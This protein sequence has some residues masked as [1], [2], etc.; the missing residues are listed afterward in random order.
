MRPQKLPIA[1]ENAAN[2][3]PDLLLDMSDV[4]PKDHTKRLV[5]FLATVLPGKI[6]FG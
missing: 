5:P 4:G 2:T 1:M 6:K 3:Q